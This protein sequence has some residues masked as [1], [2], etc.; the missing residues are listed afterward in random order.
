MED[1]LNNSLHKNHSPAQK[2]AYIKTRIQI[3]MEELIIKKGDE[4]NMW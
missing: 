3:I 4:Q 2:I 1:L